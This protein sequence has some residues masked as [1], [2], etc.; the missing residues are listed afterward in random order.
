MGGATHQPNGQVASRVS[1]WHRLGLEPVGARLTI[2]GR[3]AEAL[4]RGQ[5]TPLFVYDLPRIGDNV[6]TLQ[7]ALAKTGLPFRIRAAVKAQREP[8]GSQMPRRFSW[9]R[10]RR[11]GVVAVRCARQCLSPLRRDRARRA[12][13]VGSDFAVRLW[14]I[15]LFGLHFLSGR[16]RRCVARAL[17]RLQSAFPEDAPPSAGRCRCRPRGRGSPDGSLIEGSPHRRPSSARRV[18]A[19]RR[20]TTLVLLESCDLTEN[21]RHRRHRSW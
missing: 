9:Q 16:T 12:A 11:L 5:S 4:A 14:R 13:L 3:D 19:H 1:W 18:L 15:P 7:M 2:R 10:F 21:D 8:Q 20:R 6:G 17:R